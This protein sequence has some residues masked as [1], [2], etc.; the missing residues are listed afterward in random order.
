MTH[1]SR[2]PSEF[3]FKAGDGVVEDGRQSLSLHEKILPIGLASL[4]GNI[5]P[6]PILI[7]RFGLA[8]ILVGGWMWAFSML[9]ASCSSSF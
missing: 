8:L 1:V 3:A 6:L 2:D 4:Q 9:L 5:P 7:P